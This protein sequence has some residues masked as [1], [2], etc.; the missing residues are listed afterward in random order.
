MEFL[1]SVFSS[2]SVKDKDQQ[3]PVTNETTPTDQST[4]NAASAATAESKQSTSTTTTTSTTTAKTTV[5]TP[6]PR[7]RTDT[8]ESI[9]SC[10]SSSDEEELL[11]VRDHQDS[12]G[13]GTNESERYSQYEY[14]KG[15]SSGSDLSDFVDDATKAVQ[16]PEAS[17]AA[18]SGTAEDTVQTSTSSDAIISGINSGDGGYGGDDEGETKKS[19][20]GRNRV[21]LKNSCRSLL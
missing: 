7:E 9:S 10:R 15:R 6:V 18:G 8:G 13:S 5:S 11:L 2:T 1:R 20:D 3:Q 21:S 17:K 14:D 12:V 4:S 16:T 19:G